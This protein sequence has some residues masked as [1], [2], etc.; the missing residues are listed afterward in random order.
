V[1][2]RIG[3]VGCG[4]LFARGY[5]PALR[6][7]AGA[8]LAAVADPD[9]GRC[10]ELAPGTPAFPG[11]AEMIAAGVVDALVLATPCAAHLADARLAAD[12]GLRTLVEK[13]PAA[14]GEES[15][16]LAGLDP[17]PWIG[18][19]RRFDPALRRLRAS[20]PPGGRL[21]LELEQ[22]N[23][24]R[25]GSYVVRDDAL[26]ALGPHLLDLVG[27]LGGAEIERVRALSVAP[28]SAEIEAETE[29]G[30]ARIRLATDQPPRNVIAARDG[31]GRRIA[32]QGGGFVERG[33]A[34]LARGGGDGLVDLLARQLEEF[35]RGARGGEAP[36]LATARDGVPVMAAID[37]ARDSARRGGGWV[38]LARDR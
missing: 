34:W 24:G 9:L 25:W 11:A 10:V 17:I 30:A 14:S 35:V 31:D 2:L 22:A 15:A 23:P 12:A 1:T 21:H 5:L 37:A 29:R 7:T 36:T 3:V 18:F 28:R 6:R 19:N 16:S 26:L 27:W 13:P 8:A 38:A 4:R 33:L 20:L 32:R